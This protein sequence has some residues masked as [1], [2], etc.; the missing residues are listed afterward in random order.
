MKISST[1]HQPSTI[2]HQSYQTLPETQRIFN[3]TTTNHQQHQKPNKQLT[4]FCSKTRHRTGIIHFV[5]ICYIYIHRIPYT[6]QHSDQIVLP[7]TKG[8]QKRCRCSVIAQ[9]TTT[10]VTTNSTDSNSSNSTSTDSSQVLPPIQ[11]ILKYFQ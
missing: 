8:H 3:Q 4:H 7:Q 6:Q 5:H 1:N 11:I 9:R 2:N 10:D